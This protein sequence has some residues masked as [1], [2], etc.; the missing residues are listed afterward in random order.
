L[1]QCLSLFIIREHRY[2][3]ICKIRTDQKSLDSVGITSYFKS[4]ATKCKHY[5]KE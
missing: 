4:L 3:K 1:L 5:E 2:S